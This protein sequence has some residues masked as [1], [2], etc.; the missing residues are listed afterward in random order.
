[1]KVISNKLRIYI[2]IINRIKMSNKYKTLIEEIE[3]G[4]K[5]LKQSLKLALR[6]ISLEK[7]AKSAIEL[8][9]SLAEFYIRNSNGH[10]KYLEAYF[11]ARRD[12]DYFA[13]RADYFSKEKENIQKFYGNSVSP[14]EGYIDLNFSEN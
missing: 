2:I 11:R 12:L 1:M 9:H 10:E 8:T 3:K 4:I 5:P 6:E 14:Y 7:D 13:E